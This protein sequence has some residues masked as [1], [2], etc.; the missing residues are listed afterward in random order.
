MLHIWKLLFFTPF[1][2]YSCYSDIKTR[3][4]TNNLWL[5]M[6]A[7]GVVFI[8]FDILTH[9]LLYI[10][11]VFISAG[12]MFVIV[13]IFFQLRI[14][15]GADAKALI[16]LSMIFPTYPAFEAFEYSFPLHRPPIDSFAFSILG[17]AAVLV[18]VVPIG[19]AAYNIIKMDIQINNPVYIFI[20]Y[21]TKISH[22]ANKHVRLLQ[23]LDIVNGY[24]KP[25]YGF[26][27]LELNEKIID[28]LKNL[29]E[30][31]VIKDDVWVTPKLPFMVPLTIGFFVAVFY[32][33]LIFS[34][35]ELIKYLISK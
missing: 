22:L 1:L 13:Y 2:F 28:E 4:V 23:D 6:L 5:I 30:K 25:H 19:L 21:K 15:G 10:V 7:S 29:S 27:E 32:G 26:K 20:G 16:I 17:N 14:L 34:C 24:I 18:M 35:L 31:G 9:G 11:Y 8:L 12:F 3:R 33:D